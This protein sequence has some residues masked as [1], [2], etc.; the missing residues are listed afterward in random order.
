MRKT[1]RFVSNTKNVQP[2]FGSEAQSRNYIP[3]WR[4][5]QKQAQRTAATQDWTPDLHSKIQ[6]ER[7]LK[8]YTSP[9]NQTN[10]TYSNNNNNNLSMAHVKEATAAAQ[11][12]KA[13]KFSQYDPYYPPRTVHIRRRRWCR[14]H[15][16]NNN[17]S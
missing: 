6:S 15:T 10:D 1:L 13:W 17:N 12:Q 2:D 7:L 14:Q 3:F 16:N 5:K 8:L 9:N 4:N 11:Q